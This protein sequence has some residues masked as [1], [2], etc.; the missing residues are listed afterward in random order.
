[1]HCAACSRSSFNIWA[2]SFAF[3]AL[4]SAYN[5][6]QGY[7][8]TLFP[9][10]LGNQSLSILYGSVAVFVFFGTPLVQ[11]LGARLAM[12]L[13]ALCYVAYIASLILVVPDVVL[14]MSVVIGFGAAVLWVALGVWVTQNSTQTTRGRNMGI[15]WSVFQVSNVLGPLSTFLIFPRL[16]SESVLFAGFTVCGVVGVSMLLL[17]RPI[18]PAAGPPIPGA[19]VPIASRTSCRERM[20]WF[21]TSVRGSVVSS[22]RMILTFEMATLM[23]L[24]WFSGCELSF[25]SG[26]FPLLFPS[27]EVG[28]VLTFIGIGEVIGGI[29]MGH[30]GDR[31]GRS[32]PALLGTVAYGLA[33]GLSC[34]IQASGGI[35]LPVVAS[36]PLW[37]FIA[38]LCFGLADSSFNTTCYSM[39][40]QLYGS[41]D[42]S[43]KPTSAEVAQQELSGIITPT[44]TAEPDKQVMTSG[45]A[46]E[47]SFAASAATSDSDALL[48]VP[49]TL[50]LAMPPAL[51]FRTEPKLLPVAQSRSASQTPSVLAR[52]ASKAGSGS[53]GSLPCHVYK[54]SATEDSPLLTNDYCGT[55]RSPEAGMSLSKRKFAQDLDRSA[56]A[57]TIFQ[58]VQNLGSALWFWVCLQL[59]LSGNHATFTQVYLQVVMLGVGATC[60]FVLDWVTWQRSRRTAATVSSTPETTST[61]RTSTVV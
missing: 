11:L 24:V 53:S 21:Y 48:P 34:W 59:P 15:F 19:D 37:G 18:D 23:P 13:G 14:I 47:G 30:L 52:S 12:F 61:E 6:L 10:G 5:T 31:F 2:V 25:W 27:T 39:V 51:Q 20:A 46:D 49:A 28:L 26:A 58:L 56:V 22:F 50:V 45:T 44:G 3:L 16:R 35:L 29:A 42:T 57:F 36:V 8:T 38:A 54:D 1:M 32:V 9:S 40:S 60:F 4:F 33:L 7:V 55:L 43:L 41:D 17:L